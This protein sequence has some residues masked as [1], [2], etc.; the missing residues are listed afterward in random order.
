MANTESIS[1]Y[2]NHFQARLLRD[3]VYGNIRID[4]AIK[5][6]CSMIGPET[7]RILDVGCGIG[8]S[9]NGYTI[10]SDAVRVVGVDISSENVRTATKLFAGKR[11]TFIESDVSVT[12]AGGPF[13]LVAMIDVYEHIPTN[14]RAKFHDSIASAM[15][16]EALLVLTTPSPSHQRWLMQ[17]APEGLQIVDEIIDQEQ[18]LEFADGIGGK[19]VQHRS[20][21]M[22]TPDQYCYTVI[23][24]G[25]KSARWAENALQSSNGKYGPSLIS[26]A[27]YRRIES[28]Y[29]RLWDSKEVIA[30]RQRVKKIL[31]V[32][33]LRSEQTSDMSVGQPKKAS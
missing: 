31:G 3:Y 17:H 21:D 4:R 15:A 10:H 25:D 6:V 32:E 28:F 7:H 2:Y 20:V 19:L 13:D 29:R 33:V 16:D 1:D 23:A 30:R 18:V 26:L 5:F 14:A 24:R 8:A 9:A 27:T 22:W 12:P 11:T